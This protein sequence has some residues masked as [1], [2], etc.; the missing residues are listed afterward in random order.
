MAISSR[1]GD[2][3]PRRLKSRLR[4][5][6][7]QTRLRGFPQPSYARWLLFAANAAPTREGSPC[8]GTW[9]RNALGGDF[10]RQWGGASSFPISKGLLFVLY[11]YAGAVPYRVSIHPLFTERSRVRVSLAPSGA[12][13]QLVERL[14][15][16][17]NLIASTALMPSF[18][19]QTSRRRARNSWRAF[20]SFL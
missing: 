5:C 6:G 1:E 8:R 4:A 10:N 14:I 17:P 9:W 18:G 11:F 2:A 13:A 16:L 20:C 3:P 12:I 7:H 19:R 15:C